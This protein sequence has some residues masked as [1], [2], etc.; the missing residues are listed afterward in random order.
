[1]TTTSKALTYQELLFLLA[2]YQAF[3]NAEVKDVDPDGFM[4]WMT[5]LNELEDRVTAAISAIE[6]GLE[7]PFVEDNA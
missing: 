3:M 5:S 1:M 7:V 6:T 2:E 4:T